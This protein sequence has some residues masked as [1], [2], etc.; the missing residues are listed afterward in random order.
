ME[1]LFKTSRWYLLSA[2]A[3]SEKT[4]YT[5]STTRAMRRFYQHWL[6]QIN[7]RPSS[8]DTYSLNQDQGLPMSQSSQP[9]G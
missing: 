8:Q 3:R 6:I 1:E 4:A 9:E 2:K 5:I 7:L